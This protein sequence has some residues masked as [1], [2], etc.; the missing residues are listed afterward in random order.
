MDTTIPLFDVRLP[1]RDDAAARARGAREAVRDRV[2]RATFDDAK[3]MLSEIVTNSLR[4]AGLRPDQFI[5]V[6]AVKRGNRIRVEVAD[7]GRGF[8][9]MRRAASDADDAGWG[10]YIVEQLASDWGMSTDGDTSVW[11]EVAATSASP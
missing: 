2:P 4:H 6:W 1:P 7:P 3:L 9:P 5:R 8:E 10:L 11:F